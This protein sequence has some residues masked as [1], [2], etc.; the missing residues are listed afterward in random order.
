MNTPQSLPINRAF[1]APAISALTVGTEIFVYCKVTETPKENCTSF[2]V[3]LM[4]G[5]SLSLNEASLQL[6]H[7]GKSYMKSRLFAEKVIHIANNTIRNERKQ[8]KVAIIIT[9]LVSCF[10]TAAFLTSNIL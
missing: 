6:A 2:K 5:S 7:D 10:A 9:A 1:P 4:D 3:E 8:A